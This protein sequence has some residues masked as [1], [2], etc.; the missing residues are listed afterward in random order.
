MMEYAVMA[1][2]KDTYPIFY[3]GFDA[4]KSKAAM[5][6]HVLSS[7]FDVE[8]TDQAI[9]LIV[10][11][12]DE[13]DEMHTYPDT[14]LREFIEFYKS[15]KHMPPKS[16][17]RVKY[18]GRTIFMSSCGNKTLAELKIEHRSFIHVIEVPPQPVIVPSKKEKN[19]A[20]KKNNKKSSKKK[21]GKKSKKK[22]CNN[23]RYE[24]ETLVD[25]KVSHSKRLT[26]VFEE[27]DPIFKDIRQR[28]SNLV[29][30]RCLPK[31]K[32]IPRKTNT[33]EIKT[34]RNP[35]LEG[36]GGKAGMV[37]FPLLVG[38]AECLYQSSKKSKLNG[39][40][41]L[42]VDLHG[43]SGEAAI[44][45]LDKALP[46]WVD[47]AMRGVYPFVV[48]VNVICG[49]GNQVLSEVV[50]RWIRRNHQVANRPKR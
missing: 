4:I 15:M 12:G 27:V 22:R 45:K 11:S 14:S 1:Q 3:R 21:G 19:R 2:L 31:D 44:E 13:R 50:E 43:C 37:L 35:P 20:T 41:P 48:P 30:A 24:T 46:D 36:A 39:R 18:M 40:R 23:C 49:G 32:S 9:D 25:H 38:N 7:G 10:I 47:T 8:E 42:A 28:L 33:S 29:L 5:T 17:L 16:L 34:E 6:E 26:R